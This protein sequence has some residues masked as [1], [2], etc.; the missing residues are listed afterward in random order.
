MNS[1]LVQLLPGRASLRLID[2]FQDKC[3]HLY[4]QRV[5][6]NIFFDE[7]LRFSCPVM[8]GVPPRGLS[9]SGGVAFGSAGVWGLGCRIINSIQ[10]PRTVCGNFI[11]THGLWEFH[12]HAILW[13]FHS[14]L[15][16]WE[17]NSNTM[18]WEFYSHAMS[19]ELQCMRIDKVTIPKV[20]FVWFTTLNIKCAA[21]ALIE[22]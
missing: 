12:S 20:C 22:V 17:W 6:Q 16:A 7:Q 2:S 14:H 13:E 4:F 8:G 21:T 18:T 9:G 5:S 19:W 10:F 15:M 11:P 3:V 1:E